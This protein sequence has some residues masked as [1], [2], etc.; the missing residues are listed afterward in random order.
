MDVDN[1]LEPLLALCSPVEREMMVLC[2]AFEF[3]YAE[4]ATERGMSVGT[5]KSHVH[6]AKLKMRATLE[7]QDPH[8]AKVYCNE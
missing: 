7:Q 8:E 5:V 3:T 1:E 2:Y 4:I 6:R